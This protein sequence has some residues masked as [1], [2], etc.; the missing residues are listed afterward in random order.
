M[1]ATDYPGSVPAAAPEAAARPSAV[2]G[3]CALILGALCLLG[4]IARQG[5]TLLL[6]HNGGGMS[7]ISAVSL[8][9]SVVLG[10]AGVVAVILG[11]I[12][13]VKTAGK[14]PGAIGGGIGLTVLLPV[15]ANAASTALAYVLL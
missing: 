9:F 15:L 1:S 14:I 13:S 4:A 7:E 3:W 8:G 6:I 5:V 10:L 2:L 12:A 11:I